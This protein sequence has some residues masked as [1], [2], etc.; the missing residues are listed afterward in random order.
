MI[1]QQQLS[2]LEFS[3]EKMNAHPST[4]PSLLT[5]YC[6]GSTNKWYNICLF[7]SDFSTF[8]FK[9]ER[10][11]QVSQLPDSVSVHLQAHTWSLAGKQSTP[12]GFCQVFQSPQ[13]QWV[14]D[15]GNS[16]LFSWIQIPN[17]PGASPD[18]RGNLSCALS[19]NLFTLHSPSHHH[20]F[21]YRDVGSLSLFVLSHALPGSYGIFLADFKFWFWPIFSFFLYHYRESRCEADEQLTQMPLL[22]WA[23]GRWDFSDFF[24]FGYGSF[25][26]ILLNLLHYCFCFVLASR[27]VGVLVPWP[28]VELAPLAL[29][30]GVL[31]TGQWEKSWFSVWNP[32]KLKANLDQLVTVRARSQEPGKEEVQCSKLSLEYLYKNQPFYAKKLNLLLAYFLGPS[33][34]L[35]LFVCLEKYVS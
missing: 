19:G 10:S 14:M 26:K 13:T 17:T 16:F 18:P 25:K 4:L 8:L 15:L 2:I 11:R 23:P 3:Q 32:R 9:T 28:R 35:C 1:V 29:E 12:L 21:H 22:W 20:F 31:T 5:I 33:K 27:L 7:L 6:P 34:K 30:G 24:L